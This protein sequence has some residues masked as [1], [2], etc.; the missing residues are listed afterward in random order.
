[1]NHKKDIDEG[2][3]NSWRIAKNG[4]E[5]AAKEAYKDVEGAANR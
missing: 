3:W 2:S 5:L 1:M 4:K